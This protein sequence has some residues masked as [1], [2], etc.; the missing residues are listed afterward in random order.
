MTVVAGAFGMSFTKWNVSTLNAM[1]RSGDGYYRFRS[2]VYF[3][4]FF[5]LFTFC[6]AAR[7]EMQPPLP[8]CYTCK[9][10][11][12]SFILLHAI[13]IPFAKNS[14][15]LHRWRRRAGVKRRT[16]CVVS[17]FPPASLFHYFSL[18]RWPSGSRSWAQRFEHCV[19]VNRSLSSSSSS[20]SI[21]C[22]SVTFNLICC[23]VGSKRFVLSRPS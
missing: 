15:A 4:S 1:V 9:I 8:P 17:F 11:Y 23:F 7:I 14:T 19:S 10:V 13:N 6:S 18:P 5:F 16:R 3:S 2:S 22:T 12:F 21:K 20:F